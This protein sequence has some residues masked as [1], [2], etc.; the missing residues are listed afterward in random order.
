MSFGEFVL[1]RGTRHLLRGDVIRH[2]APKAFD[3]L[4]LLITH[5]PNVVA[6]ERIRNRLWA[7]AYVS[8]STLATVVAEVRAA[9][10]EDAREPRFLR[11]LH[12]VGY[13]FCGEA[14]EA[15]AA[16]APA[17]GTTAYRLILEDREITLRPGENL[18][19]R[20]EEGVA[21]I[22]APTV[23]RRHARILVEGGRAI[24][25]DLG[26][27]NGTFVR[28]QRISAPTTL[29][30]GDVIRLGRVSMRVR[31]VRPDASTATGAD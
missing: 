3:L 16:A 4:D 6:K 22:E 25:E 13:A 18:L 17:S 12:G 8:D 11:T 1:D 9:L 27:K 28:G 20:V 15:G 21:W 7:G 2:L 5:R 31:I 26:S 24:L 29:A 30:N 10:D 23:S 14:S 19:G